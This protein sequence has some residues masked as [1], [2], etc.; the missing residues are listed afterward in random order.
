MKSFTKYVAACLALLV[1]AGVVVGLTMSAT[2]KA[3][4]ISAHPEEKRPPQVD[5]IN[6]YRSWTRVNPEPVTISPQV[7]I[8]CGRAFPTPPTDDSFNPH[9]RKRI[10]VYVNETGTPA[11]MT[12]L[13]PKFPVGSVIVKEK[14][15]PGEQDAPELLTVMVK[16]ERGFNP[17]SGDWEYM[18][19][20]GDGSKIEDRGKLENCQ[21]CHV[22]LKET[23]FVS[24]QYLPDEVRYKLR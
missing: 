19:V 6:N 11:M 20:N 8:L 24:R 22:S 3:A 18:V 4:L 13:K 12:Q 1:A 7:S 17:A 16:R 14:R 10:I 23:D 9:L 15:L 21:A 2:P 5:V